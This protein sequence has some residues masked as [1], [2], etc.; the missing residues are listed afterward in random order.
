[1]AHSSGGPM[2]RTRLKLLLVKHDGDTRYPF[3]DTS[4]KLTI[5]VGHNLDAKPLSDAV[6][7]LLLDEDINDAW[8]ECSTIAVFGSLDEVRQHVMLDMCFNLGLPKLLLFVKMLKALE[9]HDYDLAAKEML[10]S[11]W[12]RQTQ[13][14]AT[15]LA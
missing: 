2:N 11:R 5:G 13:T 4:G 6:V 1:M 15:D 14:R 3:K 8:R 10:D 9:Q 7:A 12:A